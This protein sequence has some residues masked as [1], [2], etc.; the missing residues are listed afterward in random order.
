VNDPSLTKTGHDFI[1]GKPLEAELKYYVY[2][3]FKK[4][5]VYV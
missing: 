4:H 3:T 2:D 1:I 5:C